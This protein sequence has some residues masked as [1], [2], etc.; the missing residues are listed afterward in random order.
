MGVGSMGSHHARV[1]AELRD[2][3]LVGVHDIDGDRAA[4]VAAQHGTLAM[5]TDELLDRAEAVS[6]AVPTRYHHEVARKAIDAGVDLLVEKPLAATVEQGRELLARANREGVTLQVGHVERFNP[7]VRT[8]SDVVPDLDV[9][10]IDARR[11][12]PPVDRDDDASVALDLMLHDLD[13]ALSVVEG[14]DVEVVAAAGT[15]TAGAR[16][17][18]YVGATVRFGDV[19]GT[20]RASRVT[21]RKVRRLSITAEECTV[22]ADYID[23]SVRIFRQSVPEYVQQNGDVRY[24]HEGIIERPTVE[25]G[26][27]LKFQLEAFLEAVR[28]GERPPVT[29]TDG[30]RALALAREIEARAQ[31]RKGEE[32]RTEGDDG[33][34]TPTDGDDGEGSRSEE[35]SSRG[36]S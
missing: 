11:L 14:D 12:G 15:R 5:T 34:K 36:A 7:A 27:P 35:V 22:V 28:T 10:G 21:Q 13:V 25:N 24:R 18:R 6:V 1:Y 8:L 3:E 23:R 9:I 30:L 17:N 16:G 4:S 32:T 26:E 33:K 20:F 31:G 2:A 29:G 19:L